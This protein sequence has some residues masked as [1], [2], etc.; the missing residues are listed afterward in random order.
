M[1]IAPKAYYTKIKKTD[2]PGITEMPSLSV[3]A[4]PFGGNSVIVT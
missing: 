4:L 2:K 1:A 3:S